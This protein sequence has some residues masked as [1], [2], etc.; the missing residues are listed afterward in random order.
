MAETVY[1]TL[2]PLKKAL[3]IPATDTSEDDDLARHLATASR[4]IDRVCGRRFYRDDT[5]TAKTFPIVGRTLFAPEGNLLLTGDIATPG[6]VVVED[7]YAYGTFTPVT[8][9]EL[10]PLAPEPGWPHTG[11]ATDRMWPHGATGRVRV[12]AVWGWPE[13]PDDIVQATLLQA[14]RLYRRKDSP[15]GISGS[16]EWGLIRVSRTDPDVAALISPF[17]L[18][19]FG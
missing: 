12:T 2:A 16:A 7:G 8:Q 5:A 19:G 17:V 4:G 6:G 13:V 3:N 15:E 9:F 10:S 1:A 14:A 11:V 18:P